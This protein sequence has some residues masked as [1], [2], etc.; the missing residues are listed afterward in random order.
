MVID[1]AFEEWRGLG[2]QS[3]GFD[4]WAVSVLRRTPPDLVVVVE[5]D[6]RIVGVAVGHDY[7]ADA[8]GWIEQIAVC[9]KH[10]GR[11]LGRALLEECFR[12]FRDMGRSRCGVST[13]SRTGA[14]SLYEHV[15]MSVRRSYTR[16]TKGD[17]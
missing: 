3:M 8:E 1:T 2:S 11:G 6:G 7:G 13:D 10:R 12:R 14:L 16:W 4:N 9:G 15:G 5:C 17:L